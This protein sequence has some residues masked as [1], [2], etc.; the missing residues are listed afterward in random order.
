MLDFIKNLLAPKPKDQPLN[1]F[2]RLFAR[3]MREPGAREGFY[4]GLLNTELYVGGRMRAPG[5][6]ELQYYDMAGEKILPVFSDL[7]RLRQ[8]LGPEAANLKFK[9]LDLIKSVAPGQAIALNPYS[10]LGREFS[11]AELA[12]ILQKAD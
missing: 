4:L 7:G 1:D 11:A 2:E 12:E 5:E 8:V 3:A 6:A 9:G 10:D